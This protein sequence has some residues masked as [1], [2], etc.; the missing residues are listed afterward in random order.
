MCLCE[1]TQYYLEN[2]KTVA[3]ICQTRGFYS[4]ARRRHKIWVP[5]MNKATLKQSILFASCM[6]TWAKAALMIY[7]SQTH[8]EPFRIHFILC[9]D[10]FYVVTT[11]FYLQFTSVGHI[12]LYF[13]H[14]YMCSFT[15]SV[16]SFCYCMKSSYK[17]RKG[18]SFARVAVS[19]QTK[20]IILGRLF[21]LG[22]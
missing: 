18:I 20:I 2:N 13:L 14:P 9:S 15:N 21:G 19:S 10:I 7:I 5:S 11:S 12:V 4:G 3:H 22:T 8:Q 1:L 16:L 6:I 17:R